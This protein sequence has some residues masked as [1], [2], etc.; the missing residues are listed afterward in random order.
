M[1][2]IFDHTIL[3]KICHRETEKNVL[4]KDHFQFRILECPSCKHQIFHPSDLR[5]YEDFKKL[6]QRDFNVKL[7]MVGNSFCVSIPREIIA[8]ANL[9]R[10]MDRLVRLCLEEPN[11][12]TLF[13]ERKVFKESD[14]G[15]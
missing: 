8:F 2:D 14:D 11:K 4:L 7:R 10:E 5:D 15:N 3:C 13:F 12:L 9:E 6:R 1:H